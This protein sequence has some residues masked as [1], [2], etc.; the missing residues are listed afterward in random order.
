MH[1]D[2]GSAGTGTDGGTRTGT[3]GGTGTGTGTGPCGGWPPRRH[4]PLAAV[5]APAA[6]PAPFA[7]NPVMPG[8]PKAASTPAPVRAFSVDRVVAVVNDEALTQYEINDAKQ[9]VLQQLK[10]QKV[11][12]PS[13]DVLEKQ[14]L[15]RLITER[16]LL[17]TAKETGVKVDDNQIERAIGRIAQDNKMSTDDLRKELAKQNVPLRSLSR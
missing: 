14:V 11:V 17:Q 13:S 15:E 3:R 4:R 5:L 7:V 1:H 6:A 12:P 16:S 10:Q 2:R 9:I 8:A